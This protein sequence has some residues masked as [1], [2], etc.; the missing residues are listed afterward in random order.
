[1]GYY[2]EMVDDEKILLNVPY[3]SQWLDV[4]DPDWQ[5]RACGV[6]ALKMAMLALRSFSEEGDMSL[7]DLI[8]RGV[9]SGAYKPN[10]GW[11][12][13][14]LV[15]LAQGFGFQK[16]FRQEWKDEEKR[17]A[18]K[19]ISAKIRGGIPVIASVKSENGGHLTLLTG[20]EESGGEIAGF[21]MNDP[22]SKSR[23]TGKNKFIPIADFLGLWKGRIIVTEK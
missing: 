7:D 11:I 3:Y 21:Y 1:M 8:K 23:G 10:V 5:P 9:A 6:A 17:Q 15:R 20:F 16:S 22:D 12:H 2:C 4:K 18:L 14:G 19:F 13:D